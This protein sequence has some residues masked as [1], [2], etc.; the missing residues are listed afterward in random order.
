M[1]FNVQQ[2][3]RRRMTLEEERLGHQSVAD[4]P[5]RRRGDQRHQSESDPS[6]AHRH[7]GFLAAGGADWPVA[8][9]GL[10][11]R[12]AQNIAR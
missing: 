11:R 12:T 5:E 9:Q 10:P 2:A 7:H 3:P 1:T 6:S 4:Q 8:P